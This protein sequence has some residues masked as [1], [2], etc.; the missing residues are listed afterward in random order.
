MIL[1]LL[2][3]RSAEHQPILVGLLIKYVQSVRVERCMIVDLDL[4]ARWTQQI[5]RSSDKRVSGTAETIGD[6]FSAWSGGRSRPR[7][8]TV[9]VRSHLLVP[10]T[11]HL[12]D[13]GQRIHEGAEKRG[14]AISVTAYLKDALL[15]ACPDTAQCPIILICGYGLHPIAR[16]AAAISDQIVVAVESLDFG[17]IEF[18]R[19][20]AAQFVG[21]SRSKQV[22][23]WIHRTDPTT[24]DRVKCRELG[25][26][27]RLPA[28][29]NA[30]APDIIARAG[31]VL[32]PY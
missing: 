29:P 18:G 11:L 19:V 1:T 26:H 17:D 28:T 27:I 13:L 5:L 21:A 7:L 6:L 22:R 20:D 30:P 23:M 31:H 15:D 24:E 2:A 14:Y 10:G 16:V 8:K 25:I 3:P 32:L 9:E 4:Q 12:E